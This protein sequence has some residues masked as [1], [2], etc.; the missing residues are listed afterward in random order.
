MVEYCEKEKD[1]PGWKFIKLWYPFWRFVEHCCYFNENLGG[2]ILSKEE[3]AILIQ[4][5]K[6]LEKEMS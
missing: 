2:C 4:N 3:M 1:C 5:L 6:L